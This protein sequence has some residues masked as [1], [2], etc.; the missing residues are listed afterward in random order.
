MK[1]FPS[2][3]Y[4]IARSQ[5]WYNALIVDLSVFVAEARDIIFSFFEYFIKNFCLY[6]SVVPNQLP[7]E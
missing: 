6:K 3:A 2:F 4:P 7:I 5:V 1:N